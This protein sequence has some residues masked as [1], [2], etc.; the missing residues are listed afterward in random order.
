M[1][2]FQK[3]FEI[4]QTALDAVETIR[5]ELEHYP[6]SDAHELISQEA[7]R[8]CIYTQDNWDVVNLMRGSDEMDEALEMAGPLSEYE[9]IDRY[10]TVLA[11]CIWDQLISEEFNK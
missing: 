1:S 2:T 3:A 8:Q 11:Y 10:M 6:D 5:N 9:S 7:D 4:R